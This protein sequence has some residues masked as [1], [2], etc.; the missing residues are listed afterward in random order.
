MDRTREAI[1]S[2][3]REAN[4]RGEEVCYT[5]LKGGI[6]RAGPTIHKEI[7]SMVS[8]GLLYEECVQTPHGTR[9]CLYAADVYS[10]RDLSVLC[11]QIALLVHQGRR[12]ADSLAVIAGTPTADAEQWD[13]RLQQDLDRWAGRPPETPSVGPTET[14][15]DSHDE[16]ER[17]GRGC[18]Q[19]DQE[20]H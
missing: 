13:G 15:E 18:C 19:G 14:K 2:A 1:L 10:T 8:E 16:Q 17:E 20:G 7:R 4:L 9:K 6:D 11:H 5:S 12:I 3:V